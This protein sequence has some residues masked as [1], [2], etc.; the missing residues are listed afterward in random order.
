M[1]IHDIL[2]AINE[3]APFSLAYDWDNSGLLIGDRDAEVKKA[4][5][6]LDVNEDTVREAIENGCDVIVSHHPM[7]FRG[8]RHIDYSTPDGRLVRDIVKS[9]LSVI[10]AHTNMDCAEYG[11]NYELARML[12]LENITVLEEYP[13]N[14]KCGLG[15][16]GDLKEEAGLAEFTETVKT[17]LGVGALRY[18]RGAETIRRVA[19]AGGSCSEVIPLAKAKG[20]DA[21]VTADLKYHEMMDN[22]AL[23]IAVIDPGHYG[24]E[25]HVISI[26]DKL[27]APLGI[28]TV[29]SD[30]KD[31]FLFG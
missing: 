26:F 2:T 22:T 15:R 4:L 3:F 5:I 8:V 29:L 27:L 7:F 28:E 11:I 30:E 19:V 18:S 20:A 10:A 21:I 13:A 31:V 16:I 1:K 14:P 12:E 25:R 23:G 24:T 17:R 6:T 9:G